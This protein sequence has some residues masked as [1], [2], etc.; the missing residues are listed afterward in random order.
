MGYGKAQR[1]G[2]LEVHDHLEFGRKLHREIARL[3]TAQ[4]A[5]HV[6]GGATPDVYE[7]DSVGEQAA[8]SGW[9]KVIRAANI[10]AE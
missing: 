7:I 4:N 6:G 9:G 2:S 10:K 8:V 3:R 1:L 5:V